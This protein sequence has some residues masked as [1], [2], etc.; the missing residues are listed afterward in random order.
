ML[1]SDSGCCSSNSS[2][3]AHG[4]NDL[5]CCA[6]SEFGCCPDDLKVSSGPYGKAKAQERLLG[7]I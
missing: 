7:W 3:P 5:G 1:I 6:S 2:F 4:L